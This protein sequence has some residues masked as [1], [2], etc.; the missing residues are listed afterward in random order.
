MKA[1]LDTQALLLLL[2]RSLPKKAMEHYANQEN[3]IFFSDASLIEIAIK[4]SLGKLKMTGT[5]AELTEEFFEQ[6]IELSSLK[7]THFDELIKLPFIHKDPFDRIIASQCLVD[8]FTL[9][10]GDSVFDLYGVKRVWS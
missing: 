2:S 9:L 3:S 7:P 1:L 10:S 8:N 6:N 4:R 5:M